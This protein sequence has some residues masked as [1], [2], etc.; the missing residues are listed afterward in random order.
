MSKYP[1]VPTTLPTIPTEGTL[2][3]II[4]SL[5]TA[6]IST[7]EFKPKKPSGGLS[8]TATDL[9]KMADD[10][11]RYEIEKDKF[12]W[13]VKTVSDYNTAVNQLIED[14]LKAEAGLD[15]VP[16]KSRAKVWSKAW[17]DGHSSGYLEVFYHLRE[18]VDLFD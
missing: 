16:E 17:A 6:K 2:E 4:R 12:D 7:Y 5:E 3:Q 9:R 11:D 18:L 14:Y 15:R 1:Q 13:W 10:L 8:S